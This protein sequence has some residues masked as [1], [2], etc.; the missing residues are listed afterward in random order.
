MEQMQLLLRDTKKQVGLEVI[1]SQPTFK[2]ALRLCKSISGLEDKQLAGTLDIDPGQWARIFTNGGH[3]PENKL[4]D[5]MDLCANRVPLIWLAHKCG[6]GL[7]PLQDEKD[8]EI[9]RLQAELKEERSEH[10][11]IKTFLREI[12]AKV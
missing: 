3:F 4:L 5:F 11:A 6:Y 8:R 12:G 1:L 9:E 2:D 10:E 7:H